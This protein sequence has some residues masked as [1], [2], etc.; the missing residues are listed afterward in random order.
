MDRG[1]KQFLFL[2]F[3]IA[4][5]GANIIRDSGRISNG[6]EA[7]PHQFPW[8]VAIVYPNSFLLRC[9]EALIDPYWVV[10]AQ[11]C[12]P[13][14]LPTIV[15]GYVNRSDP[16]STGGVVMEVEKV[17]KYKDDH[18]GD[19]DIALMRLKE[20]LYESE[21]IKYA[22][23]PKPGS[24][25][26]GQLV[27]A[28]GHGH[29]KPKKIGS[30]IPDIL[31]YTALTIRKK[32]PPTYLCTAEVYTGSQACPG[33]SGGSLILKDTNIVLGVTHSGNKGCG[34]PDLTS[35]FADITLYLDWIE[36]HTGITS[37]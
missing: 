23:L 15:A 18:K 28:I 5:T 19:H 30:P 22:K 36:Q 2:L 35:Y 8:H 13:K 16:L 32:C 6:F 17:I 11:H 21:T 27:Y 29:T 1:R 10:T 25:F 14:Y 4:L 12:I 20:P 7:S 3:T 37:N 31:H 34:D 26:V 33:D 24:K 9:G